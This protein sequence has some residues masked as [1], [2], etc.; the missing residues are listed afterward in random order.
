MI[1]FI[2]FAI[3]GLPDPEPWFFILI[4]SVVVWVIL[5]VEIVGLRRRA[6]C[7]ETKVDNLQYDLLESQKTRKEE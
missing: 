1:D 6:E 5:S 4:G 2:L 3:E 7:L